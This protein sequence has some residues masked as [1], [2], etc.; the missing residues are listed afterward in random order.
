MIIIDTGAFYALIDKNDGNHLP[1][2][3]FY[4]ANVT[5]GIF[6]TSLPI[7]TETSILLEIRLGSHY[8]FEFG[9]S[10]NEGIFKILPIHVEQMERALDI[11]LKYSDACFGFVDTTTMALLET[12]KM[13]RIFTFDRKH[14][15]IYRP[16]FTRNLH[17]LP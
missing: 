10:I 15:S 8:A 13:D 9:K 17:I 6:C 14:F 16:V 12:H 11:D 4:G 1:A 3:S 2:K 5:K 7:I